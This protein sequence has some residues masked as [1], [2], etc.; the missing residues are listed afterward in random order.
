MVPIAFPESVR[1]DRIPCPPD[2]DRGCPHPRTPTHPHAHTPIHPSSPPVPILLRST[3]RRFPRPARGYHGSEEGVRRM[4]EIADISTAP[5][6]SVADAWRKYRSGEAVFVDTRGAI[7]YERG[8]IPGAISM[9]A[10][11]L[12]Q[13]L[14]ELPR[15]RSLVFY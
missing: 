8:H 5:R 15:D 2:S 7:A 10:N 14:R 9:P 13:R 11:E 4:P 12:A 1:E 3:G 6:V